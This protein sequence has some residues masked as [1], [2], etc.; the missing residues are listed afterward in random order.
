MK[1]ENEVL[2]SELVALL[3]GEHAHMS[4]E[5]VVAEIPLPRINDKPP[6]TPYSLWHFVEHIRIA[7]WDILEF[8]RNPLHISPDYPLGYR[9]SPDAQT[10]EEGWLKT[11]EEVLS[12]L[13]SLKEIV[14]DPHTELFAPL[15]HAPSY[16]IFREILTAA[17]HN[18]YHIGELALVRQVM[19]LWPAN[20]PYLT[21]KAD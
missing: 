21:G 12:D 20:L 13:H 8:I 6:R 5:E 7:Q 1:R 9:P 2:R 17:D 10:D 4:F 18:A 3:S 14:L 15:P 16:T 11:L 19:G